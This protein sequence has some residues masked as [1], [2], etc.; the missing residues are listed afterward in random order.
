MRA[1]QG[2]IE[3]ILSNLLSNAVKYNRPGGRVDLTLAGDG[4]QVTITVADTGIGMT[5]EE[6]ARLFGEF[7]RIRNPQTLHIIGSG[8][9]LSI[10]K[11]LAMLYDGDVAVESQ[12]DAGSTF[13]VVLHDA[14]Q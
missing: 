9:G 12:P 1:D 7:V 11:K 10:V 5:P 14:G 3:M 13:R 8:L 6:T 2:E 4:Q